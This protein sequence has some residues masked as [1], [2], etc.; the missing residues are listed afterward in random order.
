M[1]SQIRF[2]IRARTR[3]FGLGKSLSFQPSA[4]RRGVPAV[5][6]GYWV[7]RTYT[8]GAVGEKTK[9]W[10]PGKRPTGKNKRKEK[11]EIRKQ[12]QNEYSAVKQAARL[13][14]ENFN[15]GDLLLGLDYSETGMKKLE[16]WIEK[17]GVVL[18]SLDEADRLQMLWDAAD[19][20]LTNCMRRASRHAKRLGV[21]LKA[22]ITTSDMDGETGETVRVHHH[23]V[24]NVEA[25]DAFLLAWKDM[26]S[27]DWEDMWTFQDDRTPIAEYMLRQVRRIPDA[28]KYRTTRNLVRPVPKDRIVLTDAELRVPKGGKLLF[29]NEFTKPGQAQY[30]RY[31]LPKNDVHRPPDAGGV[32]E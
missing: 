12:A 26:G 24:I 28:K 1:E 29:R 2:F 23:L 3:V 18:N 30:I 32:D 21:Q 17:Q 25:K 8:A 31:L 9:F 10:I 15:A 20:E 27:V 14:N 7:V 5:K 11:S 6:E 19:H 16:K 4:S 22:M 13:L